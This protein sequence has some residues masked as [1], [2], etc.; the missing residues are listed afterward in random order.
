MSAGAS[1]GRVVHSSVNQ[2]EGLL[3]ITLLQLIV[4][5]AG[6]RTGNQLLRRFG[7][8][9]VI[10]EIIAGLVLGPSLFGHFF[11]EASHLLFGAKA[12]TPITI[13]SQIGLVLLMFQIGTDF[14]FGHLVRSRN[15]NG[16]IG[17]AAAS[18]TIP[19]ALGFVVGQ[20]S[21]PI[22]PR[23]SIT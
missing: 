17:I 4:M 14:E 6:A 9:G 3:L 15:R 11:P 16:A 12:S 7:Q 21:A 23:R 5:I 13:I 2:A 20:L 18:V 19:L 22:S 1:R 10:G 8:P